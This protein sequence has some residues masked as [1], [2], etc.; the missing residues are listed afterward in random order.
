MAPL[1]PGVPV[2]V[3]D[4]RR[5]GPAAVS[6]DAQPSALVIDASPLDVV[7]T[8]ALLLAVP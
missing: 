8:V 2:T 7:A 6:N 5:V 4:G 3:A 1:V